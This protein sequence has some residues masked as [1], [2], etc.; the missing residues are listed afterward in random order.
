MREGAAAPP[1]T[2]TALRACNPHAR[3][4]SRAA[5]QDCLKAK[6]AKVRGCATE[7]AQSDELI[8]CVRPLQEKFN[9]E[10]DF[11]FK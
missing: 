2:R 1:G 9:F 11:E 10:R 6:L 7:F 4:P 5:A 8:T 3:T